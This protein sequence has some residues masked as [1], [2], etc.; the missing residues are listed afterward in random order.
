MYI[1]LKERKNKKDIKVFYIYVCE[2]K[3]FKGKVKNTQK[4]FGSINETKLIENDFTILHEAIKSEKWTS[5]EIFRVEDKLK[6][7]ALELREVDV[8][9]EDN[10]EESID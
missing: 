3:R 2:S 4:Y 5:K 8:N 6:D 1:N 10:E 9:E 7:M